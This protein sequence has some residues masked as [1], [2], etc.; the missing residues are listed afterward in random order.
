MRT[1]RL[2]PIS[3]ITAWRRDPKKYESLFH[4][5]KEQGWSDERI[6]AW[7]DITRIM[8]APRDY[9]GFLAHEVF[10][11]DMIEKYGLLS[12]WEKIDKE[13]AKKIGL[14]EDELKLYWMD[15]WEH[16]E[17]GTIRELRHR[18]QITDQDVKDWFRIVEILEYWRCST[19]S[20]DCLTVLRSG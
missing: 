5:I 7:K 2:D 9:V 15:H 1:F 18:D 19:S 8:P 4:D 10:E 13:P 17:W 3:V 14:L 6:E 20:G 12:E 16:P 11:K